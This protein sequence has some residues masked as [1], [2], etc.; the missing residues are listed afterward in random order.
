MSTRY[1]DGSHYENHQRAAELHDV[2]AHAHRMAEEDRGK[3]DHL[4]GSEHSRLA[5]EHS[6]DAHDVT[7]H[8]S[9]A[10]HGVAGFGHDQ[11]ARRAHELWQARGCPEGSPEVD[12]F[13]AAAELRSHSK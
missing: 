5:L 7:S 3:Q 11:I 10:G 2:A 13:R 4:T 8:A 1:N 12:W 9:N 6:V